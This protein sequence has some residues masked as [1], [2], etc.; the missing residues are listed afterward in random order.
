MRAPWTV[1]AA[2]LALGLAG[3][4]AL[5]ARDVPA[6]Q[7]RGEWLVLEGDFHAH[8]RF[9]DGFLSPP[10]LVL[11]AR[12]RGLHVLGVTEHNLVFPAKIARWFA[13]ATGALPVVIVG[14]EVT[15]AGYHVHGLGLRR[16]VTPT[17]DIG[18]VIDAIHAQGG[19]VIA[20]HPTRR[21]WP[22]LVPV[23]HRLDGAELMHPIAYGEARGGWRWE[24]L[25]DYYVDA[26]RGGRRLTAI[27]ASDYHFFSPLGLC[28]TLV[29]AREA[30]EGS[31]LEALRA[32]RTVVHDRAG[33]AWGDPAMIALLER[34]PYRE[35]PRDDGYQAHGIPDRVLRVL[36]W[37]GLIGVLALRRR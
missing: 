23:R 9:S 6:P 30:T 18:P 3:G 24:D 17:R 2:C 11:H 34:E 7:R 12:R 1:A 26:E 8:T 22:A 35:G 33:R 36:G 19:L 37:L 28:R 20:A 10:E 27:G 13:L 32:G 29:F 15:S 14:E 5:D 4:T 21:F 31:V 25:R 16:A